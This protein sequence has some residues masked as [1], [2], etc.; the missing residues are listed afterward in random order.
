MKIS[1]SGTS[2]LAAICSA[3]TLQSSPWQT[4]SPWSSQRPLAGSYLVLLPI[5]HTR[6]RAFTDAHAHEHTRTHTQH[7]H[8]HTITHKHAYTQR[9]SCRRQHLQTHEERHSYQHLHDHHH[10]V[11]TIS[12]FRSQWCGGHVQNAVDHT[13][14]SHI[15]STGGDRKA[16]GEEQNRVGHR[17]LF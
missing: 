2:R 16:L 17:A 3:S 5:K 4:S 13:A 8:A 9:H 14:A 10:H 15:E 6:A 7:A 12:T 1:L 11:T